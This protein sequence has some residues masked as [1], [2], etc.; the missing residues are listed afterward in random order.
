MDLT[1][2][3]LELAE[4][5]SGAIDGREPLPKSLRDYQRE[6]LIAIQAWLR[7]PAKPM[8]GYV[9]HAT[10]LGKTVL[11][12]TLI[13]QAVGLRMLVILP[14]KVLIAQ[15]ARML[16]RYVGGMVGH[17]STLGPIR[18]STKDD[19]VV[20]THGHEHQSV[21]LTTDAGFKIH[22]KTLVEEFRPHLIIRDECH[23]AYSESSKWALSQFTDS[24]ILGF[25]A[26]PDYVGTVARNGFRQV[27]MPSGQ[28]LY[29]DPN[30][31]AATHF[32][33][34]LDQR[35]ASWG[36]QHGYLC[37]LAWMPIPFEGSLDQVPI[38]NTSFGY[39]YEPVA[40]QKAVKASW[41][42]TMRNVADLYGDPTLGLERMRVVAACVGVE[43]A[44]YMAEYFEADGVPSRVVTGE[45]P[46]EERDE[47]FA[48]FEA[49]E[50]R[51]LSSVQVLREGWDSPNADACLMLR[52]I[53]SRVA[54]EQ[55]VG[56][57]LR[58]PESRPDK[59]ALVA[60]L[61]VARDKQPPIIAPL[62]Y[63]EDVGEVEERAVIPCGGMR[64]P[65]PFVPPGTEPKRFAVQKL[66]IQRLADR[67][68]DIEL[69]GKIYS[70]F[71]NLAEKY[72]HS[73]VRDHVV[74]RQDH[75]R[76]MDVTWGGHPDTFYSVEDVRAVLKSIHLNPD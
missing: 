43:E 58:R 1:H 28:V 27:R 75:V 12:A 44:K 20:A 6:T 63:G 9:H 69:D 2:R 52:P 11:F 30:R 17:L 66:D 23:W 62:I 42:T 18:R 67:S 35:T 53:R 5:L 36:M 55:F 10:G 29:G 68:G 60:D 45:T 64:H 70:S 33:P 46:D 4:R 41:S 59:V 37:P 71:G 49:G 48:A 32:G 57:I 56:R 7:D 76:R 21:V 50:I 16:H 24:L 39:D 15:T 40:L 47:I 22:Y 65:S 73:W 25:S 34:C 31:F 19:T 72:G 54:Y 74:A 3:R 38:R 8:R 51:L 26:T 61:Y 14:T 13:R